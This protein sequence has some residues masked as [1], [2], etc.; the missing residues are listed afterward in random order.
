MLLCSNTVFNK[1]LRSAIAVLPVGAQVGSPSHDRMLL[2]GARG[3]DTKGGGREG[4]ERGRKTVMVAVT[5]TVMVAAMAA[6]KTRME[7]V[8]VRLARGVRGTRG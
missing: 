8:G 5:V 4:R 3:S 1:T 7:A 2:A 6:V